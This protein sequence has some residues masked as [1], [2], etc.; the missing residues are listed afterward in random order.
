MAPRLVREGK[1]IRE[2]PREILAP[3]KRPPVVEGK[4]IDFHGKPIAVFEVEGELYGIDAVCPHE[5]G[6]LDE[7]LVEKGCV[8]CPL[9]NYCFNLKSGLCLNEPSLKVETYQVEKDGDR[10]TV[11]P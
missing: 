5:G 3:F 6:P 4:R 7:G 11:K 10:Y 9:H 2:T 1:E 8:T